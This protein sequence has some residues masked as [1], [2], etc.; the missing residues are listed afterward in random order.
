MVFPYMFTGFQQEPHV[1]SGAIADKFLFES[2]STLTN[3]DAATGT[4]MEFLFLMV[5]SSISA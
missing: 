2:I 1:I 3:S 4:E 5:F